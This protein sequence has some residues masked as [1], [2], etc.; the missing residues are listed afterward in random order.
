M[1]SMAASVQAE[2]LSVRLLDDEDVPADSE[3]ARTWADWATRAASHLGDV[4]P[5]GRSAGEGRQ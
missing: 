2:S 5:P 4:R 3:G 1:R